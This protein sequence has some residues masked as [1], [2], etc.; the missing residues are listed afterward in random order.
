MVTISLAA[1][2]P[3][4]I[5]VLDE[6]GE[7]IRSL[8]AGGREVKAGENAGGG[9]VGVCERLAGLVER[10]LDDSVVLGEEVELDEVADLGDDILGLEVEALV[11]DGAANE[12]AAHVTSRDDGVG[13]SGG[14]AEEGGS[15]HGESRVGNHFDYENIKVLCDGL[16]GVD[17]I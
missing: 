7:N 11:L 17:M 6:E 9:A 8:A 16:I 10:R 1:V 15:G 3:E 13:S 14:E 5:L 4:R 12:D 2:V